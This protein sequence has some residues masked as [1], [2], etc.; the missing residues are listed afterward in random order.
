MSLEM[1]YLI[2]CLII[3][4]AS[5]YAAYIF[6]RNDNPMAALVFL[7]VASG[8]FYGAASV[9][10]GKVHAEKPSDNRSVTTPVPAP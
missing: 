5:Y 4:M 2:A 7:L 3:T 6:A 1:V 8:A 9:V 10:P